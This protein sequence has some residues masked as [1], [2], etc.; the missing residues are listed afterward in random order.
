[1]TDTETTVGSS[2]GGEGGRCNQRKVG[3]RSITSLLPRPALI[4]SLS[5]P[6]RR[7]PAPASKPGLVSPPG[8]PRPPTGTVLPPSPQPQPRAA[9]RGGRTLAGRRRLSRPCRS[10]HRHPRRYK[11][12]GCGKKGRGGS[13]RIDPELRSPQRLW[14]ALPAAHP[15]FTRS[16]PPP[17]HPYSPLLLPF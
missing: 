1:M 2:G 10:P 5:P 7:T 8:P 17:A 6:Q 16:P 4:S 13:R 12:G 3:C 15:S 14:P 11:G 9:T